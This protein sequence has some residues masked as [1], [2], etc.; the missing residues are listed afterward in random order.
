MALDDCLCG[1]IGARTPFRLV[2]HDSAIARE[3]PIVGHDR[4]RLDPAVPMEHLLDMLTAHDVEI[5][6][7]LPYTD[8]NHSYLTPV[9]YELQ[10]ARSTPVVR[11][12]A[13]RLRQTG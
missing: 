12:P 6:L 7:R 8:T 13:T 10:H 11:T 2:S 1:G 5:D 4:R 3:H 9:E